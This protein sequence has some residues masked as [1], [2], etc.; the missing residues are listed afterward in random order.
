MNDT[1][2]GHRGRAYAVGYIKALMEVVNA[3]S[4]GEINEQESL[5]AGVE[6]L[7]SGYGDD[8]AGVCVLI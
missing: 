1:D 7:K 2:W 3:I 8:R 4:R 6:L 5:M